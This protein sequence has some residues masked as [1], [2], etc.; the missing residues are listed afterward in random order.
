MLISRKTI[1]KP[2]QSIWVKIEAEEG[3][4]QMEALRIA[5]AAQEIFSFQETIFHPLLARF[6]HIH[7]TNTGKETIVLPQE[8]P[9]GAAQVLN[10]YD[11]FTEEVADM[12]QLPPP[13]IPPEADWAERLPKMP[14][15]HTE[16]TILKGTSLNGEQQR[17]LKEIV[18][19]KS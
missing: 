7:V 2:K 4:E 1:I 19:R 17:K 14:E 16:F 13:H 8:T 12:T 6:T 3:L 5:P 18:I 10:I 11:H 15:N 9:L